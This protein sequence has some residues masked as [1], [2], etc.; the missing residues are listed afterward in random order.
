MIHKIVLWI[1]SVASILGIVLYLIDKFGKNENKLYSHNLI[2]ILIVVGIVFSAIFA[3]TDKSPEKEI[4]RFGNV[5]NNSGVNIGVGDSMSGTINVN[6]GDLSTSALKRYEEALEMVKYALNQNFLNMGSVIKSFQNNPP[7]IFWDKRRANESELAFQDRAKVFQ[8]NYINEIKNIILTFPLSNEYHLFKKD[9]T[10]NP[11]V[12]NTLKKT[13]EHLE[14]VIAVLKDFA[15]TANNNIES[16]TSD[17]QISEKNTL[18]YEE[19][20]INSKIEY[21]LAT[22]QYILILNNDSEITEIKEYLKLND[23]FITS[24]TTDAMWQELYTKIAKLYSEKSKIIKRHLDSKKLINQREIERII[25]DPYLVMLRYTM[26]LKNELSEGEYLGLKNKKLNFKEN[27][28]EELLRL[29][30]LSYIESDGSACA[31]YLNKAL[32]QPN[33]SQQYRLGIPL[34]LN[35]ISNPE[36]YNGSIGVML[37]E[38]D[39]NGYSWSIGLKDGDVVYKINGVLIQEPLDISSFIGSSSKED[40]ILFELLRDDQVKRI[41]FKGSRSLNCKATQLVIFNPVQI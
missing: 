41:T 22:S 26:G 34:S 13:Y 33:L 35:R 11:M 37:F 23:F 12:A 8:K 7:N 29:S 9:L 32:K 6:Q 19:K 2:W 14:E 5:S 21:L 24:N 20:L 30:K 3:L 31:Y 39:K 10:H 4:S 36:I 1:A 27:K 17:T 18:L 25:K 15:K 38:L 16:Y 28:L 40:D